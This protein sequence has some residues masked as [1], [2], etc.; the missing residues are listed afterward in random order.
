M[1][2]FRANDFMKKSLI[3]LSALL[4]ACGTQ[5]PLTLAD[6]DRQPDQTG[7]TPDYI[8]PKSDDEVKQ[9][10][11]DFIRNSTAGDKG[12][13]SAI[14]RLAQIEFELSEKRKD[15]LDPDQLAAYEDRAY[16]AGLDRT[17]Q[18][19]SLTLRDYPDDP[20]NDQILYQ[21]AQ[22]FDQRGQ[23]EQSIS[24]LQRLINDY[25][26][27]DHFGEA[28]FRL[29]ESYFSLREYSDAE[30]AYSEVIST[31]QNDTLYEKAYY[32]R[33]WSRYKQFYFEEGVDDFIEAVYLHEFDEPERLEDSERDIWNE[34]F[35]AI[36][37]AFVNMGGTEGVDNYFRTVPEFRY[38]YH[39]YEGIADVMLNQERYTDAVAVLDHFTKNYTS[40]PYLP[41]ADLKTMQIWQTSGFLKQVYAAV[42]RLYDRYNPD[43]QYWQ[44]QNTETDINKAITRELR[45]YVLVMANYYHD[46]YRKKPEQQ[47]FSDADLWYSR[48]LK[49]YPDYVRRDKVYFQ[50][51]DLLRSG[52]QQDQSLVLY[53]LAAFDEDG[54]ILDKDSAYQTVTITNA[55]LKQQ[56]D[57]TALLNKH[58]R[59]AQAYI[60]QY[61][62]EKENNAIV[63]NAANLSAK[64]N[65]YDKTI[66]L[67]ESYGGVFDPSTAVKANLLRGQAYF[68]SQNF[69]DAETIFYDVISNDAATAEQHVR[70]ADSWAAAVYKQAELAKADDDIPAAIASFARVSDVAPASEVAAIALYDAI[71]L[72]MSTERWPDAVTTIQKYQRLYPDDDRQADVAKSLSV[73][74]LESG[75]GLKAAQEF[76][77]ISGLE[78]DPELQ[79]NALWQAAELY[80]E[81][82]D[83][84]GAIRSYEKYAASYTRPYPQYAEAMYKLTTL[85]AQGGNAG[86]ARQWQKTII[87]EDRKAGQAAKTDRTN[88]IAS[89]ATINVANDVEKQFSQ[90]P[91]TEPLAASLKQKKAAMQEAVKLYGQASAY[92]LA[93]T[94][95]QATYRIAMIYK[96][97]AKSLL[98]SERPGNLNADQLEQYEILL[99]DQAFPFEDKSIEFFE[100]NMARLNEET[101]YDDWLAASLDELKVLFPVRYDRQPKVVE[102]FN[103]L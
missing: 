94:S 102:V 97:F 46:R 57:D 40:S 43:S 41:Y 44:N 74:Y 76:E 100:T 48:Y 7:Q 38:N 69:Q 32:K 19:L 98:E 21:L 92:G 81:K 86:K 12:R 30:L 60:E 22:A 27:S 65:Q 95:T 15:T 49:H 4:S 14:S 63:L 93:Q 58:V 83:I 2:R 18:L 71:A 61:P 11:A 103:A 47:D 75:Q 36:G 62:A 16:N 84:P 79:K 77:R 78:K 67:L 68:S 8:K 35:R 91:L 42:D 51:A 55:L 23:Y 87:S 96:K 25:P 5:Q 85:Y 53:E 54:V 101:P 52:G 89:E 72:S 56:P 6:I 17:I 13:L 9:A 73:A 10:Y 31:P 80:E 24:T 20:N 99:E 26:Q 33:G 50:Y 45:Q 39:I 66:A 28:Q 70:A 1:Q 88:L 3:M 59:F 34:Y 29:A 82:A 37:L 90:I 64:A